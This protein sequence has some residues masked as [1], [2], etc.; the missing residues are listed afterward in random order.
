MTAVDWRL[1]RNVVCICMPTVAAIALAFA[2]Y[3]FYAPKMAEDERLR[4]FAETE[5]AAQGLRTG[6]VPAD[7]VWT[8]GKGVT[9]GDMSFSDEFPADMTWKDWNPHG[10]TKRRDM[11]GWRERDGGRRLVWARGTGAADS[12]VRA[13]SLEIEAHD[14]PLAMR[15]AGGTILV[16][17]VA[18][19]AFGVRYFVGYVKSRDDFLAATAHDL[20]T[21]LVAMRHM[22]G[23]DDDGARSL[24]ERLM[25]L[26]ANVKDFLRLGGRRPAPE[27]KR[28]DL[29][30]AF[31]E[32]YA[33]FRDDY[34]DVLDGRDVELE[35]PPGGVTQAMGDET[36]SVQIIWNLL[37]NDLKYAAPYGDVRA[38]ISERGGRI[39]LELVDF[40][41]GMSE[42][43]RRRA[44]DRYWRAKSVMETGKGGFG[45][46]LCTA[47][48]FA[49]SMG[50][51]LTVGPNEPNGCV[52]TFELPSGKG[53]ES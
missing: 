20:S 44:F 40:G 37:G 4:V 8:R 38:R 48:E 53:A 50:G 22:I 10:G 49:E 27:A 16:V 15:V 18:A 2:A 52:F 19:T 51:S 32:A 17:L 36:L 24:N 12:T 13:A 25:R 1:L 47:R 34:R 7:F 21:P 41:P 23:V 45:I 28:F 43:E 26:V 30:A 33:L 3:S 29:A 14:Y 9:D 6:G 39:A 42:R 5:R 31:R 46:G 11:W 35:L